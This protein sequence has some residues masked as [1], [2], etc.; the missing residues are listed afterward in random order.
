MNI[1]LSEICEIR[2]GYQTREGIKWEPGGSFAL[3]Q[4]KD[5]DANHQLD[6]DGL[7]RFSPED[8]VQQ[9]Q[10]QAG[11][12][13]F[14]ARGRENYAYCID[15]VADYVFASNTFHV[16]RVSQSQIL[17]RYLTWWINQKPAQS[18][19]STVRGVSSIAFI[20]IT[21][22]GQLEVNVPTPETQA[23]IVALD[24][25]RHHEEA[26]TQRLLDKKSALIEAVCLKSLQE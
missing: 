26:L 23:K 2:G 14:L 12:I 1:S 4:A 3:I 20:S 18:Y 5:F 17:P 25:L 19:L 11:D 7:M 15:R 8:A 24:E 9:N 22:L 21:S 10:L 13:L 6:W 16:L